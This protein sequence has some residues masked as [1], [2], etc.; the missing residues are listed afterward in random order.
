MPGNDARH[1]MTERELADFLRAHRVAVI[2]ARRR[3]QHPAP[4][5]SA[6]PPV[7]TRV[8]QHRGILRGG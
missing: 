8:P 6:H 3:A 4:P 2:P 5:P 1:T 7:I